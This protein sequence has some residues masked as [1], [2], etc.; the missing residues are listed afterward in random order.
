[1]RKVD[2]NG[3]EFVEMHPFTFKNLKA[4]VK[5][6]FAFKKTLKFKNAINLCYS[7]QSIAL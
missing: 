3:L 2:R 6:W 5:T 4:L 7:R 1:M